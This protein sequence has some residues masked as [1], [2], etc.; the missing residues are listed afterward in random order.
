MQPF[1]SFFSVFRENSKISRQL[2]WIGFVFFYAIAANIPFWMAVHGLH[3][4]PLGWF[5]LEYAVLGLIALFV[6]RILATA[7]LVLVVCADLIS[8][9]SKTYYIAPSECLSNAGYLAEFPASRQQTMAGLCL[10]VLLTAAVAA[11]IPVATMRRSHRLR[12]AACL[13]AFI[14][15]CGALDCVSIFRE[16]G[17]VSLS[18]ARPTDTNRYSNFHHL[19]LS[20]YPS[21]RLVKNE[22]MFGIS[23]SAAPASPPAYLPTQSAADMGLIAMDLDNLDKAKTP[24]QAPNLVVVVVESWGLGTDLS[25]RNSLV[26]P[27]AAP[28]LLARYQVVEGTVPFHGSTVAGEARELCS[29]DMGFGIVTAGSQKLKGCLP[30]RLATHGYRSLAVHGMYGHMSLLQNY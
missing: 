2:P 18:F 14:L 12:A 26:Q 17:H 13:I 29:K 28:G 22:R 9:V 8:S 27:Y 10:L 15:L 4:L 21:L 11:F 6:P 16:T 7:L 24:L 19:W 23:R 20:R 30:F 25:V 3:L 5:C 1:D